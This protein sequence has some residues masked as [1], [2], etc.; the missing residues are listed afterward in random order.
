MNITQK[1]I[2]I[3]DN[4]EI[5]L[6]A[7][8]QTLQKYYYVSAFNSGEQLFKELEKLTPDLIMLDVIM[9]E[10][11]GHEIAGRIK[12]DVSTAHIPVVF[13]AA[14]DS[15][16]DV[17][18]GLSLG[19]PDCIAKDL[20]PPLLLRYIELLLLSES[21]K[22]ELESYSDNLE[23]MVEE[24]IS[25]AVDLKNAFLS[26][27]AELAEDRDLL[28]GGHIYRIKRYVKILMDAMKRNNIY[29]KEISQYDE[30][31]VLQSCQLHDIGKIHIGD[32]ILSKPGRLTAHEFAEMQ[33]HAAF[34]EKIIS[35]IESRV[36]GSAFLEY[37]KI[38]AVS[39][40]EKWDGSGYPNGL[41]GEKIPLL[42]RMMSIADVYDALIMEKPYRKAFSHDEAVEIIKD[43][44][45][46]AFDPAMVDLF[47]CV[48]SEIKAVI[49]KNL[50]D[51]FSD[52]VG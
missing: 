18:E 12:K 2:F 44:S 19:A 4:D 10:M 36:G 17:R 27:V 28:T 30:A 31:L 23:Q 1:I 32:Y 45:G 39:H 52:A 42:G 50:A 51:L 11:G 40:H 8:K 16:E 7:L 43:G 20:P 47:L 14:H 48:N 29:E 38:F 26:I 3:V 13:M 15:G 41:K 24:R 37:A 6:E 22:R 33:E 35:R 5:N 21:Q 9:S 34:G 46:T 49:N 25:S